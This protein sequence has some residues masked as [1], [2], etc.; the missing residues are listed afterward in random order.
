[1]VKLSIKAFIR[2]II[3]GNG[4]YLSKE[5]IEDDAGAVINGRVRA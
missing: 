1:M 3:V 2:V 4:A 5:R